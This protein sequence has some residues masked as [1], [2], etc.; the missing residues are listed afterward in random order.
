[1]RYRRD[2]VAMV[3]A[4]DAVGDPATSVRYTV[5]GVHRALPSYRPSCPRLCAS[6]TGRR[7]SGLRGRWPST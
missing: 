7:T 2:V 1:M 5:S 6:C 3:V 4:S